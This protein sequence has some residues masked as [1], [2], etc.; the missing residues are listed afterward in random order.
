ME[1]SKDMLLTRLYLNTVDSPRETLIEAIVSGQ[2]ILNAQE[3]I[4]AQIKDETL[5]RSFDLLIASIKESILHAALIA[6]E[7]N[8]VPLSETELLLLTG[9]TDTGTR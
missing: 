3:V 6:N 9:E 8:I 2:K 7:G 1:K 4:L 5:R